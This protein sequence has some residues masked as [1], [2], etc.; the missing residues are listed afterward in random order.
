MQ[1]SM[2][3]PGQVTTNI[4]VRPPLMDLSK[5]AGP[6]QMQPQ[7]ISSSDPLYDFPSNIMATLTGLGYVPGTPE[8]DQAFVTLL[9]NP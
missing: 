4:D 1:S 3:V 8:F 2:V 6:S 9:N 7:P 5:M